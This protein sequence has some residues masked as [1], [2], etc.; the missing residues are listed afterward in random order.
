MTASQASDCH[1]GSIISCGVDAPLHT[2]TH[3]HAPPHIRMPVLLLKWCL[4]F[5]ALFQETPLSE[6]LSALYS[7]DVGQQLAA[8][9]SFRRMLSGFGEEGGR[10]GGREGDFSSLVVVVNA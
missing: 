3:T 8:T 2:Q 1:V 7:S 9:R 4:C 6:L 5:C 10:E